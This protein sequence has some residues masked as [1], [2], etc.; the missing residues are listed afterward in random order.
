MRKPFLVNLDLSLGR[1]EGSKC[2]GTR[3]LVCEV[4]LGTGDKVN[5]GPMGSNAGCRDLRLSLA[6]LGFVETLP[7]SEIYLDSEALG[8]EDGIMSGFVVLM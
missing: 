2:I 6:P 4:I 7:D 8:G 5:I 1:F 3:W